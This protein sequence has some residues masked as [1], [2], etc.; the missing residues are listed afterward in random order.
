MTHSSIS[1]WLVA[2]ALVVTA[3]MASA[4][5]DLQSLIDNPNYWATPSGNLA[6]HR[7]TEL[8]QITNKNADKLQAA[9]TFSTGVLRGHE[10]GPLV[11]PASAT[12]LKGDTLFIH[13]AFPN[14]VFAINL[15]TLEIVWEHAPQ[16]DYDTVVPVMCC[17]TVNRG[18]AYGDGKIMLLQADMTLKALDASSGEVVWSVKNGQDIPESKGG[19]M[20]PEQG[21]TNTQAP[22]VVDDKVYVG[23]SGAE[24]G[25][26]CWMAAYNMDDGSLAWRAFSMGP[27]EDI[28]VDPQKTTHLGKPIGKD[29]SLKSWCAG[30]DDSNWTWN[31]GGECAKTS[32]QW[33][34]GGGS[35]WGFTTADPELNLLYYGTGN[36]STWNPVVRPGDNKWSMTMMARDLDTGMA[37]W[38]YQMTPH[39]EWDY[40]QRNDPGRHEGQG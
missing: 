39:D 17:D 36:P 9:W 14:N 22:L 13:S 18:L 23:C 40:R 26:R 25:V 37:K 29:S 5:S 34:T 16:Q 15:D 31:K 35:V 21:A 24:F 28:L 30:K 38:F 19:P 10:G 7:Y 33:K 32:D 3:P 6:G 12:G 8:N 20:G 4:A 1:K 27:D 11:L 2:A